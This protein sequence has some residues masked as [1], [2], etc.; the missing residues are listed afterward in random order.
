MNDDST[1]IEPPVF[2]VSRQWSC[3][4]C[5]AP[6]PV[7]AILAAKVPDM[8]GERS[9]LSNIQELPPSVLRFIEQRFRTF[10]LKYSKTIR[11]HRRT[12]R[13]GRLRSMFDVQRSAGAVHSTGSSRLGPIHGFIESVPGI[14]YPGPSRRR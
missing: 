12:K 4:R 5:G 7:L 3:W 9:M 8:H 10:K 2:L 11:A 6:M 14:A 1:I 13:K